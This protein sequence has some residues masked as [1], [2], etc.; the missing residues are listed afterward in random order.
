[1]AA[2]LRN[3]TLP[4]G[5]DTAVTSDLDAI[6]VGAGFAG[7]TAAIECRQKG[8]KVTL[9]ES[10][11]ELKSLGDVI[12]FGANGARIFDRWPGVREK[13]LP[14]NH[15]SDR[16]AFFDYK[17]KHI[18]DQIW[19]EGREWGHKYNGHRGEIHEIVWN[20]AL[21]VG[22][23]IQ[24]GKRVEEYYETDEEAGVVIEGKKIGAD[25]VIAAD[26]VRSAARKI[27]LGYD[28]K[29]KSS[30]YA[31]FRTW[32][33]SAP[34]L[35]NPE[36]AWLCNNGDKHV[37]WLGPDV[38]FLVATVKNGTEVSWVLTHKVAMLGFYILLTSSAEYS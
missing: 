36:T 21:S 35:A 4:N 1:M 9:L 15:N 34:L 23:D 10:F 19:A 7:L 26:G 16:L 38:H 17:G 18:I 6:I 3:S 33:D 22:V 12:S 31:V 30:G 25:V 24:L 27:V 29:P 2:T 8:F 28:D 5:A 20:Y 37:G 13:L 32:Y 11:K 14:I